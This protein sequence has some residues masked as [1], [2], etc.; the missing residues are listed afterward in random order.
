MTDLITL[1]GNQTMRRYITNN[2]RT[3]RSYANESVP[4]SIGLT[5]K[6]DLG[7]IVIKRNEQDFSLK[8]Y[9]TKM[10]LKRNPADIL[11]EVDQPIEVFLSN[12]TD[13]EKIKITMSENFQKDD[14]LE[15]VV[16]FLRL[17]FEGAGDAGSRPYSPSLEHQ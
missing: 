17:L 1:F 14:Q 5:F 2:F 13:F 8:S 12:Q 4:L 11:F 15:S 16:H 3:D 10:A 9:P 7:C 6:N